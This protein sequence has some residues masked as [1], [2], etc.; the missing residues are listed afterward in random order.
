MSRS[1]VCE[2]KAPASLPG[3]A[4]WLHLEHVCPLEIRSVVSL[5]SVASDLR[6]SHVELLP[7]TSVLLDAL[8]QKSARLAHVGPRAARAAKTVDITE[9]YRPLRPLPH[10]KRADGVLRPHRC[11]DT[12]VSQNPRNPRGDERNV[13]DR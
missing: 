9:N 5:S 13:G 1:R 4:S 11:G 6:T 8:R 10:L 2:S 12:H 7:R 3:S